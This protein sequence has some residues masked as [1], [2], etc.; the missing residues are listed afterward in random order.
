MTE[1][2]ANSIFS[3]LAKLDR[4]Y[5]GYDN[6]IKRIADFQRESLKISNY[7]PY[8]IKK[9]GENTYVIEMAVAGFGKSDIEVTLE[10]SKLIING[11]VKSSDEDDILYKGISNREFTRAFTLADTI[12]VKN[13]GL[14]NGMLRV[15]L[16]NI[17]P[18]HKKPR[19]ITINDEESIITKDKEVLMEEKKLDD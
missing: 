9:T 8:N 10:D 18:D 17:I 5:V 2:N 6:M 19:K 13:A 14:I 15:W 1:L 3:E 12:E 16:E 7:P 4:Y 11:K